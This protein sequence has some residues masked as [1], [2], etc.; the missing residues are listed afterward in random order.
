[1]K[2]ASCFVATCG[3]AL[4]ATFTPAV[5]QDP[6]PD[7]FGYP[8]VQEEPLAERF[9]QTIHSDEYEALLGI[10]SYD[11]G[12]FSTHDYHGIVINGEVLFPSPDYLAWAGSP[13]PQIGFDATFAADPVHFIYAGLNWEFHIA[14]RFYLSA[15]VG[16][17]IT[18]ASNLKDP[19]GYKPL[20]SRALFHLGLGL[21]Y[22]LNRHTTLQLYADHFSNADLTQPNAG[23]EDAGVRLGY[24]F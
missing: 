14:S 10:L 7:R 21:G 5:A 1:V 11:T 3:A 15:N 17:A 16:G 20:G 19:V 2:A 9:G 12:L 6:S 22:D 24:R 4:L 13:R 23:A 18:T 8:V